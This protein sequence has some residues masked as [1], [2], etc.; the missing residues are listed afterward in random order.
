MEQYRLDGESYIQAAYNDISSIQI[1]I[2][3]AIDDVN[4]V[5]REYNSFIQY[6]Y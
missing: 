2:N 5:V 1:E 6:G 4:S 3:K